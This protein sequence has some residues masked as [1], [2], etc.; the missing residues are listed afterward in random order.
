M[1]RERGAGQQAFTGPE[2]LPKSWQAA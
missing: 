2:S 1:V